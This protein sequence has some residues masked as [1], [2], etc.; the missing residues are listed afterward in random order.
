MD[1]KKV[2]QAIGGGFAGFLLLLCA[3]GVLFLALLASFSPLG[4]AHTSSLSWFLMIVVIPI[5]IIL[6]SALP[7]I[8]LGYS[9]KISLIAGF[10]ACVLAVIIFTYPFQKSRGVFDMTETLASMTLIGIPMLVTAFYPH[11]NRQKPVVILLGVWTVFLI[12]GAVVASFS[13]SGAGLT[14]LLAWLVL[15]SVAAILQPQY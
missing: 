15:P 12:L 8:E 10:A 1:T 4:G 7:A 2:V 3:E 11:G 6:A 13:Q 9:K 14:V 5:L